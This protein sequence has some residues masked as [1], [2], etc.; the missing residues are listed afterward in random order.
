[1]GKRGGGVLRDFH[2][3]GG[4][5]SETTYAHQVK[6]HYL[7]SLCVQSTVIITDTLRMINSKK[8]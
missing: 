8:G 5:F 4:V 1:M 7:M 6:Y 2:I 3:S